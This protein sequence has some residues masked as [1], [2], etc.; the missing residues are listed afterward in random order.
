MTIRSKTMTIKNT[1][2]KNTAMGSLRLRA[3]P[4]VSIAAVVTIGLAAP[5]AAHVSVTPST[6]EPGAYSVLTFAVPHGC[7]LSPTTKVAIKL[8]DGIISATPTRN[9]LYEVEVVTA[10]L[11]T[12][13]TGS[14]GEQ[15]TEKVDQIV[16]TAKEPLPDGQRDTFDIQ[17][18]IPSESAGET[19]VFPTIQT[20]EEGEAAWTEVAAPGDDSHDLDAPAPAF[21]VSSGG[22]GSDG[23][24]GSHDHAADTS[25]HDDPDG[26]S[27]DQHG[28]DGENSAAEAGGDADG[29]NGGTLGALGLIAGLMGLG[30]GATALART[31]RVG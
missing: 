19:L 23:S 7:E 26:A 18:Q 6:T 24:A 12:P 13:I 9:P 25:T 20:C 10:T 31:R 27:D 16:Y 1:A 8:P 30:M 3:L 15:I 22:S 5:A 2:P 17:V 21:K 14:H 28:E 11:P 4:G 29:G